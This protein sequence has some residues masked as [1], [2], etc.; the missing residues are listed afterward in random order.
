MIVFVVLIYIRI[1]S[2]IAIGLEQFVPYTN[3]TKK[4]FCKKR[5]AL[6]DA[7][8]E[9]Q[10]YLV[11]IYSVRSI[12]ACIRKCNGAKAKDNPIKASKQII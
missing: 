9:I 1:Y 10:K 2:L 12:L 8:S 5:D 3:S 4:K 6:T 7:V 11:P